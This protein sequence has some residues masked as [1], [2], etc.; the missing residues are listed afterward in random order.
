MMFKKRC[1]QWN[2]Y[3]ADTLL[4]RWIYGQTLIKL[5][6]IY[7]PDAYKADSHKTDSFFVYQMKILSK[8]F[9]CKADTG[10]D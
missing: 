8:N 2:I 3:I 9:F 1:I 10:Q 5:L 4:Q 6:Y 7:E